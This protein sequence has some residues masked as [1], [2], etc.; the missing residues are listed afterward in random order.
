MQIPHLQ[1][2]ITVFLI[3]LYAIA[4]S[5]FDIGA[6]SLWPWL[7]ENLLESKSRSK[8]CANVYFPQ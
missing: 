6:I 8:R 1:I 4:F 7:S 2:I 5:V 3:A